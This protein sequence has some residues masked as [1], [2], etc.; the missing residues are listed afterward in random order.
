[1]LFRTCIPCGYNSNRGERDAKCRSCGVVRSTVEQVEDPEPFKVGKDCLVDAYED[2]NFFPA[3]ITK[4]LGNG[5]FS[6]R[7]S[8]GGEWLV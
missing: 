7:M 2:G 8:D 6:A 4:D 5:R 3:E 1:M